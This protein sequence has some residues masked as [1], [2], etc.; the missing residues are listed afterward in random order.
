MTQ[1]DRRIHDTW[2]G[3]IYRGHS[4]GTWLSPPMGRI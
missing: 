4:P 3:G 2:H 1:I